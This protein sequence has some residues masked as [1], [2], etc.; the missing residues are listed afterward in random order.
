MCKKDFETFTSLEIMRTN[1][2]LSVF[3][4]SIKTCIIGT[5]KFTALA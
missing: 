2:I 4:P 1:T 3:L 5:L